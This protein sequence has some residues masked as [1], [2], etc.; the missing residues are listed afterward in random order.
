MAT[1]RRTQGSTHSGTSWL[2]NCLGFGFGF[3]HSMAAH[4]VGPADRISAF[5]SFGVR[6]WRLNL[7]YQLWNSTNIDRSNQLKARK[8]VQTKVHSWSQEDICLKYQ[9]LSK[10]YQGALKLHFYIVT[11]RLW[12][13]LFKKWLI[14]SFLWK[15]CEFMRLREFH[16]NHIFVKW[17]DSRTFESWFHNFDY[18]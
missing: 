6:P 16:L 3:G 5:L 8:V 11:F 18:F 10:K 4:T 7:W 17:K 12:R 1:A 9:N 2:P 13:C 14:S 15:F